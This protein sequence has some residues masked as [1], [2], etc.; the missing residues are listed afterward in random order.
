MKKKAILMNKFACKKIFYDIEYD[1]KS[2]T[3]GY[4]G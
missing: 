3:V 2:K 1:K 4:R